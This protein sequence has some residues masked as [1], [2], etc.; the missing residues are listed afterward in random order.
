MDGLQRLEVIDIRREY[1]WV[2]D[3]LTNALNV[4]AFLFGEPH[5]HLISMKLL[6]I[7]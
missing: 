3:G 2:G 5:V 1:F 6:V 7:I 4:K